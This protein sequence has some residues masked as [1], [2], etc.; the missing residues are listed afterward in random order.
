MSGGCWRRALQKCGGNKTEAA[1][2]LGMPRS[3]FFFKLKRHGLK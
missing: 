2:I 1:K 3:T